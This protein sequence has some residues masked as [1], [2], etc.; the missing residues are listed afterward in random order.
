MLGHIIS[1]NHN[2]F[3]LLPGH[4]LVGIMLDCQSE[5]SGMSPW[6]SGYHALNLLQGEKLPVTFKEQLEQH[7]IVVSTSGLSF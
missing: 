7:G 5:G 1:H 3:K 4:R 2:T 6:L